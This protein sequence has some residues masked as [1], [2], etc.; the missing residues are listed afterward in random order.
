MNALVL[1][2][3]ASPAYR[4]GIEMVLPYLDHL[5][6]PYAALDLAAMPLPANLGDHEGR[7]YALVV[8]AH[9]EIDPRGVCLGVA[10]RRALLDAARGGGGLVSF[11]PALPA[12]AEL[13]AAPAAGAVEAEAVEFAPRSH[14]VTA[15]HTPGETLPLFGPLS[16]PSLAPVGEVLLAAGGRPLLTAAVL[17]HGRVARWATSRWLHTAILGPLGGLDDVLWRSLVWAARKPF[18]LRGLPPLVAMRVDD[19]VGRGGLWGQSPLYWAHTANLHGFKPW[20]GLFIYNLTEP[21]VD[22]LRDLVQHGQATAFPHAFGRPPRGDGDFHWYER[23]LPLRAAN[24]DEF[25]YFDHQ[26]GL[27]WPDEEAARGLAA[28]DEWVAAH[29]PLPLSPYAI[30]HWGEMGSNVLPHVHDR[31]GCDL[32]ATYH[33]LDAPLEGA[34][35]LAAGPFRK[36][37]EPG[38][39]LFDAAQ[40]GKRP[41]YY[42]DFINLAGRQ[43]FLCCTEIR[44]DAGYE[45][46]PNNDVAGTVGRGVRQLRRALDSMALA[47]LFTH[48][49]DYIYKICPGAW[50]EELA[51]IAT[52]IADYNPVYVTLDDGVRYVRAT[53]TARLASC[54]YNATTGEVTATVTGR[55]DVPT[56]FYLFTEAGGEIEARLVGVPAFEGETV[57]THALPTAQMIRR[58]TCT[59][60]TGLK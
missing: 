56:H 37:E 3:S 29:A 14:Y 60:R 43:F 51:Q 45:W 46:A 57:I 49:T 1:L 21:A 44:D 26:R 4:E 2:N 7:P 31:W 17:G 52:G 38:S 39:A 8:V 40:R 33:G 27:P 55:A 22:E 30:A 10:G 53:R 25:I 59:T 24:Y 9:R 42:A 36:F 47:V 32:I 13:D 19:V 18:A 28:V 54:R 20:L 23:A 5:G 11:D 34:S 48:E 12:P 50:E 58:K 41:L 15:R 35:W 16:V 6:V